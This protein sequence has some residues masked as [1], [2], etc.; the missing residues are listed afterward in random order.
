MKHHTHIAQL[1]K[2]ILAMFPC[3]IVMWLCV[4]VCEWGSFIL[5]KLF[6][7]KSPPA[8]PTQLNLTISQNIINYVRVCVCARS[9]DGGDPDRP[10]LLN[11]H[12]SHTPTHTHTHTLSLFMFP[13]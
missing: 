8:R 6:L 5:L 2:M 3:G 7:Y 1:F 11:T 10:L 4:C 13:F 12:L 9:P